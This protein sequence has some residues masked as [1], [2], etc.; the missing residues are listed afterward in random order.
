[1]DIEKINRRHL[2][3]ADMFYRLEKGL[4]SRLVGFQNGIFRLEV[5]IHP[6]WT[7]NYSAAAAE[8]AHIWKENNDELKNAI[9]CKIYIIDT[10]TK[11]YKRQLLDSGVTPEYDSKKGV[12]FYKQQLN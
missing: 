2:F 4:S 6:K 9:A 7:K 11:P 12:L 1:M 8:M 3:E 5:I 10:K